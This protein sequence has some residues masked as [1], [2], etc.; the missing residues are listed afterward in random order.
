MKEIDFNEIAIFIKVAQTGSFTQAAKQLSMPNSTV[1]TKVSSLEKRLG[2]TLMQR[3]TRKLNLTPFGKEYYQNCLDGLALI[4]KAESQISSTQGEPQGLFRLTVP[5]LLGVSLLPDLLS[6]FTQT[7]PKVELELLLNDEQV[8][9]VAEGVDLAIRGGEL[10]DSSMIVKKLGWSYFSAFASP[11]YIKKAGMPTHPKDLRDHHCLHFPSLG[12]DRWD[13]YNEKTKT[14]IQ[15][16]IA[17]KLIINDLSFIRALALKGNGV[18]L[19]PAFICET[20]V[21]SGRL[22]RVLPE[23]C[24]NKRPLHFVYPAQKFVPRHVHA[25]I[26]MATAPLRER[27]LD[28]SI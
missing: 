7:Y 14:R 1:S 24:S 21:K 19:L 4:T 17:S 6:K 20:E 9:L 28:S 27:L 18:A 15:V 8:D 10:K 3:T 12:R 11:A 22:V 25:F 2:V 13:F 23:W 16:P 5:N 26:E